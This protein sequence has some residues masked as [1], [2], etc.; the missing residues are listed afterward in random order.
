MVEVHDAWLIEMLVNIYDVVDVSHIS[1]LIYLLAK[2]PALSYGA[3]HFSLVG[4]MLALEV[5][6]GCSLCKLYDF[7]L[8]VLL[9]SQIAIIAITI[10]DVVY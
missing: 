2:E 4:C 1:T 10:V 7:S 9:N 3:F 6:L 5:A 8:G